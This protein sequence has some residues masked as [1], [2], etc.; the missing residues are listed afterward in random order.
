MASLNAAAPS[1]Y[2]HGHIDQEAFKN[3]VLQIQVDKAEIHEV[4]IA[5]SDSAG[6]RPGKCEII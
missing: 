5:D 6:P 1:C 4:M 2:D 3:D